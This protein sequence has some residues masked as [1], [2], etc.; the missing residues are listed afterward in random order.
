[1]VIDDGADYYH[2]DGFWGR[3]MT[4]TIGP[5]LMYDDGRRAIDDGCW[6]TEDGWLMHI[7]LLLMIL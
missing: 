1:M 6:T 3:F 7:V 5:M 2:E 4:M